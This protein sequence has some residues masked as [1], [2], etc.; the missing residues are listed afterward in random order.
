MF[1][2]SEKLIGIAVSGKLSPNASI[3]MDGFMVY[4]GRRAIRNDRRSDSITS[5]MSYSIGTGRIISPRKN[6][7]L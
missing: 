2:N 3:A 5:T 1:P 7:T 4:G 6:S